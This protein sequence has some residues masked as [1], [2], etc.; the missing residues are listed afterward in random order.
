MNFMV[1]GGSGM[2]GRKTVLHM[3]QDK[4]IDNV[5]SV[6]IAPPPEWALKQ[7]EPWKDKFHYVRGTVAE[8]EDIL[9]NC[10]LYCKLLS[11]L[12]RFG[13]IPEFLRKST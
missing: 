7:Y 10:A 9:T 1:L 12:F 5:V 11:S 6:D 8:L 13:E 4:E 2:F 3:I